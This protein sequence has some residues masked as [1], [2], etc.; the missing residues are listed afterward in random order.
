DAYERT[1]DPD[2]LTL[3]H[4]TYTG[5]NNKYTNML[6]NKFN[7]DLG[8]WA[9]ACMRAYELTGEVE[10]LNRGSFL[11]TEVY[12]EWDTSYYGGGIWW[13]N[14][15]HN[16]AVSTDAQK[17]MATNAPMVITAVKLYEAYNDPYYLN[18]AT[19]IYNWIKATLYTPTKLNDNI[20]G[21]GSGTV[22]DWDF[23][24]NYGTFLG[25]ATSLYTV[26][27][28]A[29]YL[30]D[31]NF[32]ANYVISKMTSAT[33]LMYEGENDAAGFKMIFARQ[34]NRLRVE[35]GQSQYLTFLQQNATQAWN[36][37][38]LSDNII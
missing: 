20:I 17:N 14:D 23:T 5:F 2:Y 18:I 29:S 27:N 30:A 7:D 13:R 32:A 4:D 36:H 9:L 15:A 10:Y 24:Y 16:P 35:A 19:Q 38:R 31:A 25:A 1:S 28:N 12:S 8:W 21:T 22:R 11:F 26:T 3:I 6:N 34:L 37:R 33:T